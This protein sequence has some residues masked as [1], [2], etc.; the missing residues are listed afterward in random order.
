M[1]YPLISI[2][3]KTPYVKNKIVKKHTTIFHTRA[4]LLCE[5][6]RNRIRPKII[7]QGHN[8]IQPRAIKE[9][10]SN[11]QI[12]STLIQAAAAKN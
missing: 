3:P 8:K 6:T 11:T 4:L 12:A 9:K 5:R 7:E 1:P 2:I 10:G